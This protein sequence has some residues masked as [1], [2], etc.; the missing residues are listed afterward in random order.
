MGASMHI[1]GFRPPDGQWKAMKEV[2]D[3]CERAGVDPPDE[4]FNFFNG[5]EPDDAGVEVELEPYSHEFTR[6]G[7]WGYEVHLDELPDNI[8]IVRFYMSY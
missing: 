8:K 2:W 5:E 7:C 1:C 6:E 3:A 4:V